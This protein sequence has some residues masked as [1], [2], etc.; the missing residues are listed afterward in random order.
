MPT[1]RTLDRIWLFFASVKVTIV[2]LVLLAIVMSVGTYVETA[3]SNGAARV[4]VYRTWWFDGLVALLALNLIGCT[5]R[6]APY[7]PHQAGWITTHIAL[8]L[9]MAASVITHRFG[10]HGQMMIPEG[11]AANVYALEQIDRKTLEIVNGETRQ[12]PFSLQLKKFD[13]LKYPGTEMTRM[14]RSRVDVWDP[15]RTDTVHYDIVLNHPLVYDGYKISQASFVDLP[16]GRR[17][18]VLG[19]ATDPGIILM[20]FGG[21]LLVLGMAGIFYLKPY[22]KRRFPPNAARPQ[23]PQRETA[24]SSPD[25][26]NI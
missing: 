1:S 9:I 12:L 20:Y 23:A 24:A 6:R 18:T 22:L 17:A 5:L 16:D 21:G 14:F 19:I 25:A 2:L 4:L 10:L 11:D 7:K 13:Q 15:A 8:L 3:Y 26:S